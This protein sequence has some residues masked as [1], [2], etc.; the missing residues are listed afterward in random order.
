L[1]KKWLG[2]LASL[3]NGITKIR[4]R[5]KMKEMPQMPKAVVYILLSFP[6]Y[7]SELP[8]LG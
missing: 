8:L 5:W 4:I 6:P 1:V 2:I 7:L 3:G